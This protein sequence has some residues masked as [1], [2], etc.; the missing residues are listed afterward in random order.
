MTDDLPAPGNEVMGYIV[1]NDVIVKALSDRLANYNNV[2]IIR[3]TSLDSVSFNNQD[4]QVY[5]YI[6][7]M[8]SIVYPYSFLYRV[9]IYHALHY[10]SR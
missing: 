7:C 3:G 1:E 10:V 6:V 5:N 8:T 2:E 9:I 4:E